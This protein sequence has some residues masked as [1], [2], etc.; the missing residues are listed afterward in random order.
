MR[1]TSQQ[2]TRSKVKTRERGKFC[3]FGLLR[4]LC[5]SPQNMSKSVSCDVCGLKFASEVVSGVIVW[6]NFHPRHEIYTVSYQIVHLHTVYIGRQAS[7]TIMY[8]PSSLVP[9]PFLYGRGE[10]LGTKLVFFSA[11]NCRYM[12]DGSCD[13]LERTATAIC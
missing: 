5:T 1:S 4:T 9:R 13:Q 12:I 3:Y 2:L 11:S 7:V 8:F 6:I 10:T